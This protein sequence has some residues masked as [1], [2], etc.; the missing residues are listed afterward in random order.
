[1]GLPLPVDGTEQKPVFLP[2]DP[3]GQLPGSVLATWLV[4]GS[5][6]LPTCVSWLRGG[7]ADH[8][9]GSEG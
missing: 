9:L 8:P 7:H 5:V 4:S 3:G 1:M 6:T 2:L